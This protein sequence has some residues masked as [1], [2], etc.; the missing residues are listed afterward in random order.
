MGEFIIWKG[1]RICEQQDNCSITNMSAVD[2][3]QKCDT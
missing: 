3:L 2:I 1:K